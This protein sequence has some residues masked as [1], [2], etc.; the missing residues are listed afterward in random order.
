M[1]PEYVVFFTFRNIIRV[2]T[3]VMLCALLFFANFEVWPYIEALLD[4]MRHYLWTCIV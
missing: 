4:W 3:R 1:L 2:T